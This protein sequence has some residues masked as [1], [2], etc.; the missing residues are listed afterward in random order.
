V[1][2]FHL[3]QIAEQASDYHIKVGRKHRSYGSGDQLKHRSE[4]RQGNERRSAKRQGH[5]RQRECDQRYLQR[6]FEHRVNPPIKEI[7]TMRKR[8]LRSNCCPILTLPRESEAETACR[9]RA[10][11]PSLSPCSAQAMPVGQ[12]FMACAL[13]L[14]YRYAVLIRCARHPT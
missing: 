5:K 13:T 1:P 12:C 4:Q 6:A 10:G 9:R 8:P 14:P 3:V 11:S 7:F 2:V